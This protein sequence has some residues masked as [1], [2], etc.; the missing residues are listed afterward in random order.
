MI[1]RYFEHVSLVPALSNMCYSKKFVTLLSF[2]VL[3]VE[4]NFESS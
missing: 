1:P 3:M 2:T 4:S